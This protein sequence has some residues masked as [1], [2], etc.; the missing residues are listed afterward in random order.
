M[1]E[2]DFSRPPRQKKRSGMGGR[3]LY[4]L[5]GVV[6]ICGAAGLL[7]STYFA[8]ASVS[9][10]PRVAK[11]E[12]PATI[13]A[14]LNAPAGSLS[15]QVVNGT[16]SAST[17]VPATGTKQVSLSASGMITISNSF[18]TASQ[19]LVANTRFQTADGK[20]YRIHAPVVIPGATKSGD[21]LAPGTV[22]ITA[23]ADKPGAEYNSGEVTLT[24]PGFKSQTEKYAKITAKASWFSGGLVGQQPAVSDTDM[25][26]AEQALKQS[27]SGAM[28]AMVETQIP[29]EY[30]MVPGTL[31]ITYTDITQTPGPNNT[32]LL[33]QTANANA[34]VIR[35]AD[36]A[37]VIAKQTV[38]GYGGEAVTFLDPKALTLSL[39]T[40]T[41]TGSPIQ[42]RLSGSPTLLWQFDTNTLKQAL[43]GKP[44]GQF[45]AI[46]KNF[47]PAINCSSDSPCKASIRPF[48]SSTFPSDAA[49]V[50]VTTNT[51]KAEAAN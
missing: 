17:S 32:A 15:Y 3:M 39:A 51:P 35:Y 47:A 26:N 24:I 21:T 22:T 6:V 27:L 5:I 4:T 20:I 12:A 31:Q 14:S 48:W 13:T 18:S 19:E 25:A 9:V 38:D 2:E 30:V 44:K 29:E 42:I 33:S 43:L 1:Y 23:Y 49:K 11:V 36:L 28:Q 34:D 37:A 46:L 10:T 50:E 41:K 40:S 45:E 16:R 8:G 7:M